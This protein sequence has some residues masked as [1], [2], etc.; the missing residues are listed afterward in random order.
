[1]FPISLYRFIEAPKG[2]T[3]TEVL[4][5]NERW[6]KALQLSPTAMLTVTI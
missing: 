6:M 1:M 3:D 5:L 2:L 4:P